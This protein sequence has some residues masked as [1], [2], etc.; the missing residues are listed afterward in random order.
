MDKLLTY[1]YY[2]TVAC[3]T[4]LY[5]LMVIYLIYNLAMSL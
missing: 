3:R 5:I 2:F 1:L 4:F